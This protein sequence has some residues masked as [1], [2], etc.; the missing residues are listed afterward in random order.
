MVMDENGRQWVVTDGIRSKWMNMDFK[1]PQQNL[2]FRIYALFRQI[3]WTERKNISF[4]TD[5]FLWQKLDLCVNPI[6]PIIM[7]PSSQI[8]F[9]FI[10]FCHWFI[11]QQSRQ[12]K[13][14]NVS[15]FCRDLFW[16]VMNTRRHISKTNSYITIVINTNLEFSKRFWYFCNVCSHS[17][18]NQC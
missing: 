2:V 4:F 10:S 1:L 14:W 9:S 8:H 15:W 17:K 13:H 11:R 6:R 16:D 18:I 5:V 7:F 3:F 12:Q